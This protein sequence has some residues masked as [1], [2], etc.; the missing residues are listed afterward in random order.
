LARSADP[1]SFGSPRFVSVEAGACL[2]TDAWFPP[3]ASLRSHH[4]DRPIAAIT[5]AGSGFSVLGAREV[6]MQT[7]GVHTEPAGDTHSN[8]FGTAGAH[9]IAIQPDPSA[10]EL[11]RPCGNVLTEV[12]SLTLPEAQP[13]GCRLQREIAAPDS[14][15]RLAIEA[16]C[17]ELLVAGARAL[18]ANW[19]SD[20]RA[21]RWLKRVIDH[22]HACFLQSPTLSEIGDVGGVHPAHLAREF[23][24]VYRQSPA[25]YLRKLR[26]EWA[27]GR[28]VRGEESLADLAAASGFADQSH[29]TR[30]FRRHTGLTP[31]A[32]RRERRQPSPHA[33]RLDSHAGGS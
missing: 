7:A 12:H 23:R 28:L 22:M 21:P 3:Y 8:R 13:I 4:H 29:F 19:P 10:E 1:V 26:L 31:A 17:L 20:S 16:A 27:A 6:V 24:R 33:R 30:A 9:V 25:T 32:Y 5:L 2:V 15:S 14:V 18:Q 11:L